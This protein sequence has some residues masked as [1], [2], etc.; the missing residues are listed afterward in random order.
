MTARQRD[1]QA[2]L[3]SPGIAR[4]ERFATKH[5]N[6]R[7]ADDFASVPFGD[8]KSPPFRSG[9]HG[10]IDGATTEHRISLRR[11]PRALPF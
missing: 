4:S 6:E 10:V 8:E 3:G 1:G 2:S 7:S 5:I 11:T 9:A